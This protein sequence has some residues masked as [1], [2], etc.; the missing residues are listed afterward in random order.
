[1]ASI[2]A[3][4]QMSSALPPGAPDTP[5]PATREPAASIITPPPIIKA[6]VTK[7]TPDWGWPD[8]LSDASASASLRK[9]TAVQALRRAVSGV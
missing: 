3:R 1:M 2:P 9:L 8:W 4:A 5:T 7:R 6:S